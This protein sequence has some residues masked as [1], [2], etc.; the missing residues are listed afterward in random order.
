MRGCTIWTMRDGV[1]ERAGG[2]PG[3]KTSRTEMTSSAF[4]DMGRSAR[5]SLRKR[6]QIKNT[7]ASQREEHIPCSSS[8]R[9]KPLTDN[10]PRAGV[11]RAECASHAQA[12][13]RGA[14]WN[15]GGR[16]SSRLGG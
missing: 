6:W 2:D 10:E 16:K 11:R 14:V 13:P 15:T 4:L 9:F 5:R 3:S 7:W 8:P 12:G 1:D